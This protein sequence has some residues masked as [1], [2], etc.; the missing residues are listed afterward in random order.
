[1]CM[2]HFCS[3]GLRWQFSMNNGSS[4]RCIYLFKNPQKAE[5]L[6]FKRET[7]ILLLEQRLIDKNS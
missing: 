6:L 4:V 5:Y 3:V 1:M 7:M 2:Y